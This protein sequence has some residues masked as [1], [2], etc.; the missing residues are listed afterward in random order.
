MVNYKK[1][2]FNITI[3]SLTQLLF[4]SCGPSQNMIK[5]FSNIRYGD[6]TEMISGFYT[7]L[8]QRYDPQTGKKGLMRNY[9]FYP[10]QTVCKF[11]LMDDS[12]EIYDIHTSLNRCFYK[13]G[14]K[15]RKWG[16]S[17]GVYK[18]EGDHIYAEFF[19]NTFL[20]TGVDWTCSRREFI[21]RGDTLFCERLLVVG[22][23]GDTE[24]DRD[25]SEEYLF[26][27]TESLPAQSIYAHR[28][29]KRKW[30]WR[31]KDDW[32]EYMRQYKS[33]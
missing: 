33:R 4:L 25:V 8:G 14:R 15:K 10:D 9:I 6:T 1:N 12:L 2:I 30:R 5:R 3:M 22:L 17:W 20:F 19:D 23:D 11:Y 21:I 7:E 27:P 18:M 29:K 24:I 16:D 28:I 31:S 32:K 26:V 13:W